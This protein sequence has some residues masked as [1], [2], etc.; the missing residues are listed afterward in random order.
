MMLDRARLA[1]MYQEECAVFTKRT[2]AS[3]AA[4]QNT[5]QHWL[6]GVPMHWMQDWPTP[7]PLFVASARD[8]TLCD[9]DGNT[10]TDF[11]LGDTGAMFGHSPAA[12]AAALEQGAANGLTYM[13][14][15][16]DVDA[17]GVALARIFGLPFW[18][19]TL[20]ATDANRSVIR[21]SRAIT[22]RPKVL[23][24]NGCYHG[25]V[26]DTFICLENGQTHNRPGLVGQVQDLTVN[27]VVVEFNDFEAVER[28]L[29]AG[30]IAAVLTEPAL[31]NIGM[32]EPADGFLR[33]LRDATRTHG[34]L[35][36]LDETHTISHSLG[37]YTKAYD[38]Q[39]DFITMGKPIAGG[40]PAAVFGF[41]SAVAEEIRR[42]TRQKA[43]GYSGM[44]T[45]LSGNAL[46][47]KTMRAVLEQVMTQSHYD[48]MLGMA[49]KLHAGLAAS[50][51]HAL[52][53]CILQ[54]GARIELVFANPAPVNGT[55]AKNAMQ[56]DL[57]S[58]IHLYLLNRGIMIT[59][60]HNMMLVCPATQANHVDML[61]T[62]FRNCLNALFDQRI[63]NDAA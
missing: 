2:P 16:A 14:P 49:R 33:H 10:Y 26:D 31:T 18:Q 5:Q 13:L 40:L 8:V 62:E 45:T 34:T 6:G 32:V 27:S 57:S 37:G 17:V 39:P 15:T 20:T 50:L 3:Q 21:W 55:Q 51:P 58:L 52:P 63:L 35:L 30:D 29:T 11:C 38:L 53:W 4:F 56:H 19:T 54:V 24:F 59:P 47:L 22:G 23:V 9:I 7:H 43:S 1:N 60:F 46:T 28:A 61:V 48:H 12:V 41:S 44:G 25:A 42:V 36:V